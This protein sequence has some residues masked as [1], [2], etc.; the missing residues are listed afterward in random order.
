MQKQEQHQPVLLAEVVEYLAIDADG[1]YID[2]TFGRGGH[3]GEILRH[4][5]KKGRLIAI[6]K[7]PAAVACAQQQ[8]G[9]DKRFKI[10]QG[11]FK[12]IKEITASEEITG[13]VSGLLLDLGVS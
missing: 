13:L 8:W 7:D 5:G 6:D 9:H 1:I 10:Y 3:A 4:L 2:A 12:C 11:S